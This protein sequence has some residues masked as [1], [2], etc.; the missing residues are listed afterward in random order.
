MNITEDILSLDISEKSNLPKYRQ[1]IN[2]INE[3]I[4]TGRL[5]FGQKLPSINQ[6][7]Y[8]YYLSRDTVEKAFRHLKD[9][10]IIESV[11]GKGFYVTNS[12]PESQLKVMFVFD[13]LSE[14]KKIIYNAFADAMGTK[15]QIDF[16]IYHNDYQLF[17]RTIYEHLKGYHYY[18]VIPHFKTFEPS[19]LTALMDNIESRKLVLLDSLIKGL[20]TYCG[21]VFQD[22]KL[23]IF[24]ALESAKDLLVKYEKIFLIFPEKSANNYP[25]EI[26]DG[27]RRFCGF[28][29]FD[30]EIIHEMPKNSPIE[31]RSAYVVVD[32]N[33]LVNLIKNVRS[34]KLKLAKDVGIISYNDAVLKEVLAEG[35]TVIT[36]DF[37]KMGANAAKMILNKNFEE[38]KN[39]FKFIKR[40][41]L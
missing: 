3:N 9:N 34:N 6:L 16:F 32:D 21:A 24:N 19:K 26:V 41:S 20:D 37:K 2:S 10:A 17:E 18:V 23:D 38:I 35:I 25:K 27:F 30:H 11:R 8:D 29:Q 33:D 13:Q 14:N 28:N 36:T 7:S 15:A 12:S 1:L 31:K 4:E 5:G 22:F 39:D 40:K